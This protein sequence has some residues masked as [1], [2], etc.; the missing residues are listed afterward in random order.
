[1]TTQLARQWEEANQR[2]LLAALALVRQGLEEQQMHQ[3]ERD[4]RVE[5]LRQE[6]AEASASLPAPASL[7]RLCAAFGLSSF[8]RDLL[9]LCAGIELESDFRKLC[10]RLSAPEQAIDTDA[11]FA[12]PTFAL[13]L[14]TLANTHW[15]ALTPGA[16]LRHWRLLAI[17][18][19]AALT[20]SPL[21]IDE[22]V[23]HYLAGLPYW[24]ERI[25]ALCPFVPCVEKLVPSHHVLVQHVLSLWPVRGELTLAN[26]DTGSSR[27]P[28]IQLCGTDRASQSAIAASVCQQ[29]NLRLRVLAAEMVPTAPGEIELFARLCEREAVLGRSILLLDCHELESAEKKERR[30]VNALLQQIQTPVMLSCREQNH[31]SRRLSC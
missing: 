3:Q 17:R 20:L 1:V 22:P 13:A 19:G 28:V 7:L 18:H 14:A 29:L 26:N 8:E 31:R 24:D 25:N 2:Y 16:P 10:S 12:P 21:S 9:L 27:W 30:A 4:T 6:L 11:P 5:Q 15:D 23:L